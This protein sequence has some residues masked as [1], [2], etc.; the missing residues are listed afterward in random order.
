MSE[1]L[2]LVYMETRYGFDKIHKSQSSGAHKFNVPVS[3]VDGF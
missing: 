2:A 3:H 1:Q